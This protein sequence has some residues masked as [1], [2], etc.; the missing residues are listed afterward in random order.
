[1]AARL[2][3]CRWS[4]RA[5]C[6]NRSSRTSARRSSPLLP[7]CKRRSSA[8]RAR[9]VARGQLSHPLR[10]FLFSWPRPHSACQCAR[11]SARVPVHACDIVGVRAAHI[12]SAQCKQCTQCTRASARALYR[13]CACSTHFKTQ[14]S[15]PLTAGTTTVDIAGGAAARGGA[16][17]HGH[18]EGAA[19]I[20]RHG[21]LHWRHWCA[22]SCASLRLLASKQVAR[23]LLNVSC[24]E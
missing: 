22:F 11:A 15:L 2:G 19:R 23:K 13:G 8:G 4:W 14:N 18:R 24:V 21:L 6:A 12:P 10:S 3:P 16:L 7:S 17:L 9:C 1:M 20:C 5:N